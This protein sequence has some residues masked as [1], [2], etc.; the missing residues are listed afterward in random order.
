MIVFGILALVS[1]GGL[2]TT[3][4]VGVTGEKYGSYGELPIPGSGDIHLPAGEVIVSFHVSEHRVGGLTLPKLSFDITPPPG[5]TDPTVTEDFGSTVSVNDE[6]HR[7]V[8]FMRV[9]TEGSYRVITDGKVGGFVAPRLAFGQS[10]PVD[11]PLWLFVALS[12]ISVDLFIAAWWFSRRHRA[13]SDEGVRL[14]QLKTIAALR[15]SGALTEKEFNEEKRRIL[16]GR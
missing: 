4:V 14:E 11:G 6:T 13:A 3:A 8:W 9:H 5:V 15:D 12:M 10:R 2:I 7:R 1:I 16:E